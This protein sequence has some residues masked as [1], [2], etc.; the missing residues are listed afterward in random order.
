MEKKYQVFISSTYEDLTVERQE[1][2]T[3]VLNAGHIPAGMELFKAGP[4]QEEVIR[5]W[6]EESDI[7]VLILGPRYG[8]L[9]SERISYT[10]WEYNLAKELKKPMFSIVL[11][12]EYMN[13]MVTE[14]RI[15]PT[16]LEISN[17]KYIEFKRQVLNSLVV[18][19]D[20]IAQI[21]GG[22]SDSIRNIEKHSSEKLNGWIKGEY[23]QELEE[24][25]IK[26]EELSVKLVSRQD[27]VI[28]MQKEL[29]DIKDEFIGD[30]SFEL[31]LKNLNETLLSEEAL[32]ENN[33]EAQHELA[34]AHS[35]KDYQLQKEFCEKKKQ[36]KTILDWIIC[37]ENKILEG[38]LEIKRR[39]NFR[40]TLE[41][42]VMSN[43]EKYEL[44]KYEDVI[45]AD[46]S[47]NSTKCT[48]VFTSQGKKF[49]HLLTRN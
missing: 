42:E 16:Q 45:L 14:K 26:N 38:N 41:K 24:L 28:N 22:V 3:A 7:Y 18:M 2:V 27:E 29:K 48:V 44:I 25:R 32:I 39:R 49:M 4:T 37:H 11:T 21:R 30:L 6:I 31:V 36:I 5:E 23:Y 15:L 40:T 46:S 19:V 8:S 17:D 10:Q 13:T 47:K 35:G 20:H 43:L 9:N 33:E 1:V 12:D 34:E